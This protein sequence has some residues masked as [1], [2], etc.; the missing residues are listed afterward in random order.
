MPSRRAGSA[1]RNA[2]HGG[3]VRRRIFSLPGA[4]FVELP[5]RG[6]GVRAEMLHARVQP[7]QEIVFGVH[8]RRAMAQSIFETRTEWSELDQKTE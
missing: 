1:R 7:A 3:Q 6:F 4:A 8:R 5:A 2:R